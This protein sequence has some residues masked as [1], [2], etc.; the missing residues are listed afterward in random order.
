MPE[1]NEMKPQKTAGFVNSH[2]DNSK[3]NRRRIA[4]EEKELQELMKGTSPEE[5]EVEPVAAVEEDDSELSREEKSF[6]VRYGDIRR[7]MTE[8]EAKWKEKY[9][10]LENR[11]NNSSITPP[12]SDEDIAAWAEKYPDVAGIVETIAAKKAQELFAKAEA[13]LEQYDQA[14]YDTVRTKAENKIRESHPD[15]DQLREADEFH[16]WVEEQPKWVQNALYENSDDAPSVTRIIDLYKADKGLT[17]TDY[18]AKRKAA[19]ATVGKGS[20]ANVDAADAGGTIRESQVAKMSDKE[21]EK[22]ADEINLAM[23][24]GKFVY[25]ISGSA[26]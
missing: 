21:F 24:S 18:A 6:K 25:D 7:H 11:L 12:K 17:K 22:R 15:F 3:G 23:R 1:L 9:E 13:R 14:Q 2:K 4:E 20:R 16:D 26:R 19:A 5:E 10:A 8:T